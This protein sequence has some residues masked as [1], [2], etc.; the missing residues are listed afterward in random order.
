MRSTACRTKS[1]YRRSTDLS[2]LFY[3]PLFT[4]FVF[5]GLVF[6]SLCFTGFFFYEPRFKRSFL[7]APFIKALYLGLFCA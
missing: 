3:G 7:S 4:G 6:T 1:L 2:V 5:T